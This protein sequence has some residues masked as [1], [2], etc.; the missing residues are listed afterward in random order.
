MSEENTNPEANLPPKTPDY[1]SKE[2]RRARQLANLRPFVKGDVRINRKGR[3]KTF[4]EWR[5]LVQEIL[6]EPAVETDNKGIP[7][8]GGKFTLIQIP[9]IGNDGQPVLDKDGRP[10]M[11]DHYATNAELLARKWLVSS[12]RQQDLVDAGFGKVPNA[13]D[14]T[15]GGQSLIKQLP[16]DEKMRRLETLTRK[17]LGEPPNVIDATVIH[18]ADEV[19]STQPSVSGQ[20]TKSDDTK[21]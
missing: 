19:D 2:A 3:P 18:S 8:V 9:E 17:A 21:S 15:S 7:K 13:I 20:D 5:S 1:D 4:D 10:K 16:D 11:V 6:Q 12:K 14:I